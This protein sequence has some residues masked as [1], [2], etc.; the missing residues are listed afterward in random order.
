MAIPMICALCRRP[1]SP[2]ELA[3]DR[4][5]CNS[6]SPP[7]D[8]ELIAQS[9]LK[10]ALDE[11]AK[12]RALLKELIQVAATCERRNNTVEWMEYLAAKLNKCA[13][14]LGETDRVLYAAARGCFIIERQNEAQHDEQR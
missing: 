6:R 2:T 1:M 14:A 11:A 3:A 10:Q 13:E 4:S 5:I 7:D 9:R 8:S 12:F